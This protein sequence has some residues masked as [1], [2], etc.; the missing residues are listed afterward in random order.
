M[1]CEKYGSRFHSH[2]S[3]PLAILLVPLVGLLAVIDIKWWA[4]A[5]WQSLGDVGCGAIYHAEGEEIVAVSNSDVS[6]SDS[7]DDKDY[8]DRPATA[9][10]CA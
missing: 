4:V 2:A 9:S 1:C 3:D 5:R 7:D 10:P 6:S 8:N